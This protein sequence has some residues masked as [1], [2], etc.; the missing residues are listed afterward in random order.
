MKN[1]TKEVKMEVEHVSPGSIMPYAGNPKIHHEE[2]IK[3]VAESIRSNGFIVPILVDENGIILAGHCRYQ[4]AIKLMLDQVPVIMLTHLSEYQKHTYRIADNK[5]AEYGKW[6]EDLLKIEFKEIEKMSLECKLEE[7]GFKTT[8]S[9]LILDDSLKDQ[10]VIDKLSNAVPFIPENEVISKSGDVWLLGPHR[11]IC[12]NALEEKYYKSLMTDKFAQMISVDPPYNVKIN[13]H[14]CGN[15]KVKHKEFAMASGEMTSEEFQG[16]LMA[17]MEQ[18]KKFSKDGSL[19][20]IF[21]DWRHMK[22]ILLAGESVYDK[23]INLCIWNKSN[24]GMGSLYR[25]KHELTFIFKIGTAPHTNNVELGKNGRYRTNVWDYAGINSFGKEQDNLK[26][27][28]TVKPLELIR[29]AI[30][31]VTKRGDIVLDT[32]LGSGTTLIAA[33]KVGRICYGMELEPLYVDTAIRRFQG[34]TDI[35]AIHEKTG[36]TY[37]ELLQTK[38]EFDGGNHE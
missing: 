17:N 7:T 21:M 36:K 19:H 22:E 18:L 29:D 9:D 3:R 27:H 32:F 15:G 24:G 16:F 12:G 30:L 28:S 5:L 4:A 13:G 38:I 26:F 23:L 35:K 2:Q 34:I 14:V 11:V 31:D 6:D 8:E 33:E 25:S 1:N 20:Y 10:N 37:D